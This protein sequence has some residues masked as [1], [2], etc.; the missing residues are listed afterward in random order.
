MVVVHKDKWETR[1]IILSEPVA[2]RAISITGKSGQTLYTY[3]LSE[4]RDAA[5][6][7]MAIVEKPTIANKAQFSKTSISS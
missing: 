1:Q 7:P 3:H 6:I 4:G 2:K 5:A